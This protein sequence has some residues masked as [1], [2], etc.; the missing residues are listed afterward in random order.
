MTR[1]LPCADDA[2]PS[3]SIWLWFK[4]KPYLVARNKSKVPNDDPD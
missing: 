4:E 1:K 3:I 2:K